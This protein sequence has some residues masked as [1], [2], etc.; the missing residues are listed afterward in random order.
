VVL[1]FELKAYTL[2]HAVSPFFVLGLANYLP[3]LAWNRNPPD[4]CLTSM[5]VVEVYTEVQCHVQNV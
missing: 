4:L 3:W 1:G 5:T 2:S